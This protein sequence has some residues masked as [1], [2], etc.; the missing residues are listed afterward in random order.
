ML[1]EHPEQAEDVGFTAKSSAGRGN[2]AAHKCP[3]CSMYFDLR[4]TLDEHIIKDHLTTVV[5]CESQNNEQ[6]LQFRCWYCPESFHTPEEVVSHM[7][8]QH[9]SL[10]VLS[11]RVEMTESVGEND[12]SST[13]LWACPHCPV[14]VKSEQEYNNHLALHTQTNESSSKGDESCTVIRPL[15]EESCTISSSVNSPPEDVNSYLNSIDGNEQEGWN[16][17]VVKKYLKTDDTQDTKNSAV[18]DTSSNDKEKTADETECFTGKQEGNILTVLHDVSVQ[19]SE[20]PMETGLS[21][22]YTTPCLQTISEG[23]IDSTVDI[24]STT[25]EGQS[26]DDVPLNNTVD[27]EL[28]ESPQTTILTSSTKVSLDIT[29]QNSLLNTPAEKIVDAGEYLKLF[30]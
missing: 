7:T 27:A 5:R 6:M 17:C 10:D 21:E 4:S 24:S 2:T 18:P 8:T 15:D 1:S 25:I 9:E 22:S 16:E 14:N 30:L 19:T 29:S 26:S 11:K 20:Q 28:S 12:V 13:G 3:N 23:T